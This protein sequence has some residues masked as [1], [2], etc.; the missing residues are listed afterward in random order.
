MM[1]DVLLV[2][3]KCAKHTF[4]TCEELRGNCT[5]F[6]QVNMLS[7]IKRIT[8]IRHHSTSVG[9][10]GQLQS[11]VNERLVQI[12]RMTSVYPNHSILLGSND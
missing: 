3:I 5:E 7:L 10:L 12:Y 9:Q 11:N 4:H 8:Q 6:M 1:W 2:R